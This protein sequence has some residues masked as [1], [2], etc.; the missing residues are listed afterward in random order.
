VE[1][2]KE[3]AMIF[4]ELAY[5]TL[6]KKLSLKGGETID[7]NN[8]YV[9]EVESASGN[10]QTEYFDIKTGL[11]VRSQS[12]QD[13]TLVQTDYSDYRE[14]EGGIKMPYKIVSTGQMPFPLAF[15]VQSVAVNTGVEDAVFKVE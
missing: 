7:G 5:A 9:I 11:K 15:E 2:F 3:D 13:G 6:G 14:V 10:K 1:S 12:N 4:P 8:V